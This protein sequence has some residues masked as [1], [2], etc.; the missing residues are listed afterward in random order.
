MF[1]G[2][3]GNSATGCKAGFKTACRQYRYP[4]INCMLRRKKRT[5]ALCPIPGVSW[6]TYFKIIIMDRT[7]VEAT[8]AELASVPSFTGKPEQL[9]RIEQLTDGTQRHA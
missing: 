1:G 9:W 5:I 7:S 4:H 8:R 3:G 6:F 2:I